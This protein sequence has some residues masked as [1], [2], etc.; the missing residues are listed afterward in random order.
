MPHLLVAITAHGYGHLAQT[1]AVLDVLRQRLPALRLTL[2]SQLPREV[3]AARIAGDFML[4]D[5]AP[6]VGM[7]MHNALA[8]D[9]DAAGAA[10][11]AFHADW[12]RQVATE[13]ERLHA[14]APDLILANVPYRVLA[15]ARAA[16]IPAAALCSLNW[17]D[18]YRHFCGGRP[19]AGRIVDEITAAYAAAELFV[20]PEP[21]MPMSTLTNTRSVGPIA[22]I[23]T[24]RRAELAARCGVGIDER[25]IL[26]SLGG[27]PM[28][29]DVSRWPQ[30]PGLR[31]IV[32]GGWGATRRDMVAFDRLGLSF[33]DVLRSADL[34]LTKPGYGSFAEAACN[35]VPV[36]YVPRQDWPEERYLIDWLGRHG[37]CAE[38]RQEALERG[39]F[40]HTL[41]ELLG[42]GAPP[43][44]AATGAEEAAALLLPLITRH[45]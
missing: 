32:P 8:V 40:D 25:F 28:Q 26:V 42:G 45:R 15:A 27:I 13:A 31:W 23:G 22:R 20:R 16:D 3:L 4:I 37:R 36:L 2:Y 33:V 39:D 9:A 5:A 30:R 38:V 10:Y 6:D 7:P 41:H 14:Y 11:R 34:L 44:V 21:S 12:P 24:A 17:A 1:A 35:G 18:I 29:L 19:E 43:P